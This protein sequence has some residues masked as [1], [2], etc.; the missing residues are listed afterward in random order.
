MG[1]L[2][3]VACGSAVGVGGSGRDSLATVTVKHTSPASVRPV[4]IAVFRE[5]GF[6]VISEG[7]NSLG[8][9][10]QGGRSAEVAWK[11]VGNSNPVMIRPT[12]SW[13]QV[14]ADQIRLMCDVEVAQESTVYGETVRHP[15]L[16]GKSA[17]SGLLREIKRR[18]EAG[19]R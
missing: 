14:G 11:T 12:V 17:Y 3:L 10:K 18:A 16:A 7:A 13:S 19:N 8:F 4:T 5:E 15:M 6:S 1:S 9:E 2:L